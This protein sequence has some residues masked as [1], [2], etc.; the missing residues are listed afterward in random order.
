MRNGIDDNDI[1]LATI[2]GRLTIIESKG[3]SFPK[4][5]LKNYGKK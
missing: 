5:L 4:V 1:A 2:H 3:Q